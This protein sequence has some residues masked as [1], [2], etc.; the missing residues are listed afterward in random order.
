MS[1]KIE[2]P[3]IVCCDKCE[4][5]DGDYYE[6][7]KFNKKLN[8]FVCRRGHKETWSKATRHLLF[9]EFEN[10]FKKLYGVKIK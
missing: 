4:Q 1:K 10:Y 9:G 2:L 3:I 5:I 6:P 8:R 7:L